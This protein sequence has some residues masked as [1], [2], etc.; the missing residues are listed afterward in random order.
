[1]SN[2]RESVAAEKKHANAIA[3]AASSAAVATQARPKALD[4]TNNIG[5]AMM[6]KMGW[7]ENTGLGAKGQGRTENIEV[8]TRNERSGIGADNANMREA[9]TAGKPRSYQEAA[10]NSLYQRMQQTMNNN[11][12][13]NNEQLP[14]LSLSSFSSTSASSSS[15]SSTADA[16]SSSYLANK[17]RSRES[18]LDSSSEHSEKAMLK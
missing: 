16:L 2:E 15:S 10:K 11:S 8:M 14:S 5:A 18:S 7:N 17:A 4:E 9:E 3:V 12:N 6:K 13:N 1:M